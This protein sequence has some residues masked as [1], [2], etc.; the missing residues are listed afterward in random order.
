MG[1]GAMN[2]WQQYSDKAEEAWAAAPEPGVGAVEGN[3]EPVQPKAAVGDDVEADFGAEG[4]FYSAR[5][6]AIHEDGTADVF[7]PDDDETETHVPWSRIQTICKAAVGDDVEAD[8]GAEGFHYSAR[9]TAIHEDGTADVFYPDDD[10]T[11]THVPW[12]RIRKI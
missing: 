2:L 11:E 6:T 8:F 5:I 4:Y 12:S 3:A 9:V 1:N 10:E 7:Y